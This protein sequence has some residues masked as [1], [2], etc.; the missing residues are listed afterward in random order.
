MA[1]NNWWTPWDESKGETFGG[2]LKER[3]PLPW[4]SPT[5]KAPAYTFGGGG[6]PATPAPQTDSGS[7]LQS[8][9]QALQGLG[10][11]SVIP[12]QINWP[13]EQQPAQ[14]QSSSGYWGEPTG[15]YTPI[16]PGGQ[17]GQ[18]TYPSG[19]GGQQGTTGQGAWDA[20]TAPA[21]TQQTRVISMNGYDFIEVWDPNTGQWQTMWDQG[22]LGKTGSPEAEQGMTEWQQEQLN[23][24]REQAA[25]EAA[26]RQSESASEAAWRQQQLAS[27]EKWRESQL[28]AQKQQELAQ[29]AAQPHSWLEYAALSGEQPA[30]QPWMLPLMSQ[31]YTGAAGQP[32]PG[33]GAENMQGM[34]ALTTPSTQYMAR[35]GPTAQQQFQGY[36]QARTGARPEEQEFRMWNQA[37]PSGSNLGLTRRR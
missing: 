18:T 14:A 5:P 29:L 15:P 4:N 31:E 20:L 25:Q 7:W 1:N 33:W 9:T 8:A 23:L 10:L 3:L 6:I 34:P 32:I 36:R 13:W 17:L 11:P 30:V 12:Q 28:A 35:M 27:E 21:P 24:S 2:E 19:M 26:W 37:P 22:P 16:L